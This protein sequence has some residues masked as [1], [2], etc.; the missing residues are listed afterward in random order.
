MEKYAV[1]VFSNHSS[2]ASAEVSASSMSTAVVGSEVRGGAGTLGKADRG[3]AMT[4]DEEG[5]G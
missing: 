2:T 3:A 5:G 4:D 1:R